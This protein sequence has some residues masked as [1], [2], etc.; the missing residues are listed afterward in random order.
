V[1]GRIR[2]ALGVSPLVVLGLALLGVPRV[3]AHDLDLV[4]PAVNA[5]LVSVPIAVWIGFVLVRRVPNPFLTL[6]AVGVGYGVLL[7]ATHQLLWAEAFAGARPSLGGNLA[8]VLPPAGEA[9]LLR[10]I[11]FGSS[12]FTG[13]L[14]GVATGAAGWLLVRIVP[15]LGPR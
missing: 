13:A 1:S 15:G 14:T 12:L 11:A 8:G 10:V 6:L 4:G 3:V 5:M 9:L 7:G 2:R